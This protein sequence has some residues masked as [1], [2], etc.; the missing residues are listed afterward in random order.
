MA[1]K[2]S[3]TEKRRTRNIVSPRPVL[4]Y[5]TIESRAQKGDSNGC[6]C[7]ESCRDFAIVEH[8]HM[9][10]IRYLEIPLQMPVQVYCGVAPRGHSIERPLLINGYAYLAVSLH[11]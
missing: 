6:L 9:I 8:Q 2:N 7:L 1:K 4:G 11:M 10:H 5:R 3:G